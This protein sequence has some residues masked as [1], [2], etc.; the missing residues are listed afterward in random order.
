M[1]I[2]PGRIV[3]VVMVLLL[4]AGIAQGRASYLASAQQRELRTA[5]RAIGHGPGINL[6]T[7]DAIRAQVEALAA[8]RG[9]TLEGLTVASH[10][11]DGLGPAAGFAPQL[12]QT[13]RGRMRVYEVR[14]TTRMKALLLTSTEPLE[15]QVRLRSSV[16][17]IAPSRRAMPPGLRPED[18]NG[19]MERG[20]ERYRIP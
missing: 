10:E 16:E 11:E 13:L 2:T 7:D 12:A 9:V 4:G 14:G 18:L 6:P 17:V 15:A 3:F 1:E 19:A 8:E 5:I 20:L